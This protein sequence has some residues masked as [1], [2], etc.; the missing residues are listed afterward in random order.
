MITRGGEIPVR[1]L[2][3]LDNLTA[4]RGPRL[5]RE[6]GLGAVCAPWT[7]TSDV[8]KGRRSM[9]TR[10]REV[11]QTSGRESFEGTLRR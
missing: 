3:G 8:A 4:R 5:E 2:P 10:H 9:K 6:G 7:L 11:R 1:G